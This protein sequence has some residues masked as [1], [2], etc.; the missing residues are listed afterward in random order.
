MD[1]GYMGR[2]IM[3]SWWMMNGMMEGWMND[4]QMGRYM[5]DGLWVG[6][7]RMDG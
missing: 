7:R 6:V 3:D 4:E 5:M 1:G 2:W